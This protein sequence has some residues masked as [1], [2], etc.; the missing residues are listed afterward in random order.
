MFVY[1]IPP[2]CISA[3]NGICISIVTNT[4][5]KV[6][7]EHTDCRNGLDRTYWDNFFVRSSVRDGHHGYPSLFSGIYRQLH[8]VIFHT[9]WIL[10]G[11]PIKLL[12]H[13][14]LLG[15]NTHGLRVNLWGPSSVKMHAAKAPMS[16]LSEINRCIRTMIVVSARS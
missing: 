5:D 11:N 12:K 4:S 13:S 10:F 15:K 8:N 14:H 6:R 3:N 9:V 2:I 1:N 7:T 16:P